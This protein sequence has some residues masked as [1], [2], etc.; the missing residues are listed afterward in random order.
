MWQLLNGS[1]SVGAAVR[2]VEEHKRTVSG[3]R[4]NRSFESEDRCSHQ[5]TNS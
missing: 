2:G 5:L 4:E 1:G 3:A